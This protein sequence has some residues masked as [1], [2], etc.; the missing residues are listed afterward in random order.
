MAAKRFPRITLAALALLTLAACGTTGPVPATWNN[1]HGQV[2]RM[3]ASDPAPAPAA[4]P[5]S[6]AASP[7]PSHKPAA[8][9]PQRDLPSV[10]PPAPAPQRPAPA[11]ERKPP[12][13]APAR[14]AR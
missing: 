1:H 12:A 4:A 5:A 13:P 6:P 10:K 7:A 11:P 8:S 2:T 9:A 14:P 3:A